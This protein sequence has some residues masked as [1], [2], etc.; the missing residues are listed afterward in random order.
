M[1]KKSKAF[2]S[3]SELQ[4]SVLQHFPQE[5]I[6]WWI[7]LEAPTLFFLDLSPLVGCNEWLNNEKSNSWRKR[8]EVLSYL[9]NK[10]KAKTTHM[11]GTR[12]TKSFRKSKF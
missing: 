3:R 11:T 9:K 5:Q 8:S 7:K 10:R 6:I 12:G 2:F 4:A 1:Q